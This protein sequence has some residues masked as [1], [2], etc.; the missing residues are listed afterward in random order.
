MTDQTRTDEQVDGMGEEEFAQ[1]IVGQ[2]EKA[3]PMFTREQ[4]VEIDKEF[5]RMGVNRRTALLS[6]SMSGEE[7]LRGIREDREA[8]V[9]FACAA[10]CADEDPDRLREMANLIETFNSRT[11]V[12]LAQR[13]DMKEVIEE[14]RAATTTN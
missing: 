4:V 9:A 12:A 3:K 6:L 11:A 14:G 1:F 13:E 7:F 10:H 5:Q 2:I 8:A